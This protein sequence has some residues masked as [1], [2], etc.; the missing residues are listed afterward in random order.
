MKQKWQPPSSLRKKEEPKRFL[1]GTVFVCRTD[2]F[3][4]LFWLLF[5]QVEPFLPFFRKRWLLFANRSRFG[6]VFQNGSS[7]A[8][9]WL[10]FFSE[11][12]IGHGV[13]TSKCFIPGYTVPN[14]IKFNGRSK[15]MDFLCTTFYFISKL[16]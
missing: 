8:P 10:Q 14:N 12:W 4:A 1:R 9:F 16:S 2:P 15:C 11:C 7:E 5:F 6:A 13:T 3:V